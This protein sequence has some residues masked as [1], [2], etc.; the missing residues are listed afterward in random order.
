MQII[1][2]ASQLKDYISQISGQNMTVGFVPTMGYLHQG[3]LQLVKT[4]RKQCDLVVVSIFVNP[5]QFGENE[6]LDK[7]PSDIEKDCELLKVEDVDVVFIPKANDI[8]VS[9]DR[10]VV[11]YPDLSTVLCGKF[12]PG[13]F[14]GVL[15]VMTKLFALIRPDRCYMGRKDGQQLVLV[16]KLVRDLFL[17]VDI[18]QCPT[19][20]EETGLAMSS[21][22][23]YLDETQKEIASHLYIELC[24]VSKQLINGN[25][26]EDALR[27]ATARLEKK[28]FEVQYFELVERQSFTQVNQLSSGTLLLCVAGLLGSTRLIDNFVIQVD[29][30]EVEIDYGQDQEGKKLEPLFSDSM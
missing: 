26:A 11:S 30:K 4:A 13:H 23:S 28:G 7:Y 10:L 6:D 5:T 14:D 3:H 2:S 9:N 12:R 22:N 29:A 16:E 15:L 27:E 25:S 17:D 19:V 1:S 18:V 24:E 21:R 20:R 8:Y